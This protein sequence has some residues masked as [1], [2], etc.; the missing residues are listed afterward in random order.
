VHVALVLATST[1]GTGR[2]VAS[3]A[4]GLVSA[5]H[6][7]T[8]LGPAATEAQ[9]GFTER[10]AAFI[11]V[12]IPASPKPGDVAAVRALRTALRGLDELAV[13]HAHSLRAGLVASLARPDGTPLVVTWHNVP[14]ARGLR[15]RLYS[16]LERHVARAADV[17]LAVS[18]DL[19]ERAQELGAR[20]V[21]HAAV[22]A[23]PLPPP[24]R[25][26]DE[27][28]DEL[29]VDAGRPLILA[30][31]RLHP[32]K[33]H[34]VLVAAAAKL[35]ER[36]PRPYVAIAGSG[37]QYLALAARISA[38]RAPVTLIG[39]R[40]D[41]PDLLAA[42]DLVVS[43]SVWEGQPL[44]VQEALAAGAPLVATAVGGTPEVVGEAALLVPPHDVDAVAE[45]IT[46]MLDDGDLRAGYR[47]R[48][49]AQAA[50]WPTEADTLAQV[51][52][53]YTEL[54]R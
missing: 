24:A 39:D 15:G 29:G 50:T 11:A 48:G 52:A 5:G 10:G 22:P 23:P 32:Q 26:R 35:R 14:M 33:G 3:L 21:R 42:A 41:V 53:V 30:V 37:P 9:F 46:R 7:V 6:T 16:R 8:V 20:D 44:F 18:N 25:T 49:L 4:R 28:R 51:E 43:T 2:H 13:I 19:V 1:G 27:V 12:E 34:E 47:Q 38:E 45:A 17:T 36:T 31:G 54:R 40:D